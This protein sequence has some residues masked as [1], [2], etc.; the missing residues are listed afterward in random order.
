MRS[1]GLDISN[2]AVGVSLSDELNILA[3]PLKTIK[4][5]RGYRK[6]MGEIRE[7]VSDNQ[8]GQIIVGLPI[9][10]NGTKGDRA[11]ECEDFVK[12]LR[13]YVRIPIHFQDERYTT[14]EAKS[15]LNDRGISGADA[16]AD[17]DSLAA[18]IILQEYINQD[19]KSSSA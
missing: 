3:S 12:V 16:R 2:R 13:G 9:L 17:V 19:K 8:I 15:I 6:V 1:M 14:A 18:S 10:P 5:E 7:I 4:R 11:Q